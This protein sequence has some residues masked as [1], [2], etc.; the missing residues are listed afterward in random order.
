MNKKIIEDL[1]RA[2]AIA[3]PKF[4]E[5]YDDLPFHRQLSCRAEA[6]KILRILKKWKEMRNERGM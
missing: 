2:V 4:G 1:A 3:D 5:P 6:R